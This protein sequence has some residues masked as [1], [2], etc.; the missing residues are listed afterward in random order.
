MA[1]ALARLGKIEAAAALLDELIAQSQQSYVSPYL[2][3][4]VW[5]GMDR[6]SEAL[7]WLERAQEERC[8]TLVWILHD[9]RLQHLRKEPRFRQ[10]AL[11]VT[12]S[13]RRVG[14]DRDSG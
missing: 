8:E 11:A 10:V 4:L 7:D 12:P 6:S 1:H 9:P 5:A 13:G 14:G 3:S 2:V